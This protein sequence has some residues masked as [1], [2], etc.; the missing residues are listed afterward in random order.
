MKKDLTTILAEAKAKSKLIVAML[1]AEREA[2]NKE[3]TRLDELGIVWSFSEIIEV[4]SPDYCEWLVI[5]SKDG[6]DYHAVTFASDKNPQ[7]DD[8]IT[9]IKVSLTVYKLP[10]HDEVMELLNNI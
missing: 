3:Q 7:F 8:I 6:I 10:M 1:K 2:Y 9:D 5:G 4:L